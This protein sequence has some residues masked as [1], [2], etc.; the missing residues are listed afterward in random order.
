MKR[1]NVYGAS[2]GPG[3]SAL[4]HSLLKSS[5]P[6]GVGSPKSPTLK[7]SQWSLKGV[8]S[9]AHRHPASLTPELEVLVNKGNNVHRVSHRPGTQLKP[10]QVF[11]PHSNFHH[12][13]ILWLGKQRHRGVK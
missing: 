13:S 7:R 6:C 3:L 11:P 12:N 8:K 4:L 5:R 2:A 1:A 10:T 9:R